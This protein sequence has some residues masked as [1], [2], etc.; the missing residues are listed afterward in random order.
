MGQVRSMMVLPQTFVDGSVPL[1]N[2]MPVNIR[3]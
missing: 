3:T 1:R 2:A